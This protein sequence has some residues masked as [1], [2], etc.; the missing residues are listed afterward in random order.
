MQVLLLTCR[1]QWITWVLHQLAKQDHQYELTVLDDCSSPTWL[2]AIRPTNRL[3]LS[4]GEKRQLLL[5]EVTDDFCWLDD[6]DWIPPCRFA[7][8]ECLKDF[9]VVGYNEGLF[10][11][12]K[13]FATR[14]IKSDHVCFGGA[15][16]RRDMSRHVVPPLHRGEDTA[17]LQKVLADATVVSSPIMQHAWMSHEGNVV[18]KRGSMSFPGARFEKLDSWERKFLAGE[19]AFANGAWYVPD[20]SRPARTRKPAPEDKRQLKLF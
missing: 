19:I 16:F 18:G 5:N 12:V 2:G 15:L 14:R 13:S 1:P 20:V 11:D 10:V 4:L 17:W 7:M 3:Q 9:D 8:S 6:D